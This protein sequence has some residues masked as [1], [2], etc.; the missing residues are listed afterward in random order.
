MSSREPVVHPTA[1]VESESIGPRARI[2]AFVH[3]LPGASIG[4]DVNLNDHV[5][6]DNDVVIGDRVTVKAGVQLWAGMR[7]EDDVFIGPNASFA[8]DRY[9]R[10]RRYLSDHAVTLLRR[11][12][13]V[14]A[15][16]TVLPGVTVGQDAMVGAGAVVT[17]DV[18]PGATVAGNPARIIGYEMSDVVTET[19]SAPVTSVTSTAG[20][21]GGCELVTLQK[22]DDLRGS[23]TFAQLG[24]G[25]PFL[26]RRIF[27]VYDVPSTDV[28]G[29]HA[30]RRLHQFLVAVTGSV[31]VVVDDGL[32]HRSEVLLDRPNVGIHLPPMVWGVQ[33]RYSPD[34][35][36]LVLAS[37]E[38]DA[39]DY[40]RDYEEFV[41]LVRS[42]QA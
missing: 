10:S 6:I 38:Y 40:V 12:C 15:G 29:Q 13:S 9:P 16:A 20:L 22:I 24:E 7:V 17:K 2:Y 11:G 42:A 33:Y 23:L 26:P 19:W 35:V 37:E 30:H 31:R 3:V 28:R 1:I 8:N 5:L 27:Y 41:A 25:L 34:A 32:G 36:L 21:A 39:D 18:P 14:G 4:S